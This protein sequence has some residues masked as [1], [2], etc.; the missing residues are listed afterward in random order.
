MN[1]AKSMAMATSGLSLIFAITGCSPEE[2]L[3]TSAFT[4]EIEPPSIVT[5]SGK[6][7]SRPPNSA[8]FE[9]IDV[10]IEYNSQYGAM[11]V[12]DAP[13][14]CSEDCNVY[15]STKDNIL[16]VMKKGGVGIFYADA[17]G[18]CKPLRPST[19]LL[20]LDPQEAI[21]DH[22]PIDTT[23]IRINRLLASCPY[24]QL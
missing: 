22:T 24:L 23:S 9:E 11:V 10:V 16:N 3:T 6:S 19:M 13:E 14:D 1:I 12:Y 21:L 4:S 8:Y 2:S 18:L 5:N 7:F 20:L 15:G 17:S